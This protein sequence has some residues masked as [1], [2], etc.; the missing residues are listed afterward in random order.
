MKRA[1]CLL[2]ALVALSVAA[3]SAERPTPNLDGV[4][5][6]EVIRRLHAAK[7]SSTPFILEVGCL[8]AHL[9]SAE[10][11]E[12]VAQLRALLAKEPEAQAQISVNR[13]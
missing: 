8:K 7:E 5:A 12:V 9:P 3:F 1:T 2:V 4:I 11:P 6:D 13:P 10:Q